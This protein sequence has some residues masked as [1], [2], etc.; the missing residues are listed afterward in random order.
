MA[1]L[2]VLLPALR[3]AETPLLVLL[4]LQPALRLV[5]LPA[6]LQAPKP[7]ASLLLLPALWL[8][9]LPALLVRGPAGL[10]LPALRPAEAPL[11]FLLPVQNQR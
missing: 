11:L 1:P 2:L 9:P 3:P 10:L 5:L 8:M 6:A 7:V 4:T